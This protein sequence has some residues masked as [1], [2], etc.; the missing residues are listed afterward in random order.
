MPEVSPEMRIANIFCG[1][2]PYA[3]P[4]GDHEGH[5]LRA[6]FKAEAEEELGGSVYDLFRES[7]DP[8]KPDD[9][10]PDSS[11]P[12]AVRDGDRFYVSPRKINS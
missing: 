5:N 8:R 7:R 6:F 11:E 4:E 3:L 10:I 9:V 2:T 12:I 1:K